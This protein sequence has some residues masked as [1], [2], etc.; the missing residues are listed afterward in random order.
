M[1]GKTSFGWRR[2]APT[3]VWLAVEPY[4]FEFVQA[5]RL[6]EQI[7]LFH[8]SDPHTIVPLGKGSNPQREAA[9]LR[10]HIGFSFSASEVRAF[11]LPHE[12]GPPELTVNLFALAGSESPLPNWIAELLLVQQRHKDTALR[13]FLDIFHHRLLSLLYRIQLHHR[14]WL[15]PHSVQR[16]REARSSNSMSRHLLAFTGLGLTELQSRLN[17]PDEE[18]LP[19]AGLLWQKPRSLPGLERVLEHAL[20]VPVTSRPTLGTWHGI[21]PEDRTRLG[22]RRCTDRLPAPS[23]GRFHALG[24]TAT[25]G[26]RVW[27]AQGRFDLILGPLKLGRFLALLPGGPTHRRLRSLVRF[28]AGDLPEVRLH[29]RLQDPR[30]PSTRLGRSRLGWTSWIKPPSTLASRTV[31]LRLL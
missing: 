12:A 18:L 6:L 8:A 23:R 16:G 17:I 25:L 11:A 30:T 3:A 7:A 20:S 2:K 4:R 15:E 24:R 14:P 19:Y 5:L 9:S 26:T 21:E 10:S 1:P 22:P 31:S 28:Y 27:D 13:D 29:L